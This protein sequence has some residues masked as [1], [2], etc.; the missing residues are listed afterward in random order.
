MCGLWIE[1][2]F[3]I[4]INIS[5]SFVLPLILVLL[6]EITFLPFI[7]LNFNTKLKHKR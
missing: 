3:E 2:I 1:E 5:Q 6:G 7:V 4:I